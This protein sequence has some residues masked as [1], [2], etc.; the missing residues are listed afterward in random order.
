MSHFAR[1]NCLYSQHP[2]HPRFC[3]EDFRETPQTG[4]P[5]FVKPI[6]GKVSRQSVWGITSPIIGAVTPMHP[7]LVIV[8]TAPDGEPPNRVEAEKHIS[9]AL[10]ASSVVPVQYRACALELLEFAPETLAR[11]VLPT[12]RDGSMWKQSYYDLTPYGAE[13]VKKYFR[14]IPD[15]DAFNRVQGMAQATCWVWP[16]NDSFSTPATHPNCIGCALPTMGF[17]IVSGKFGK[18]NHELSL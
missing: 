7:A 6:P 17:R 9:Y 18:R 4:K 3:I 13:G 8:V 14:K 1:F 5:F 16:L 2:V 11:D 15:V 10:T 12:R